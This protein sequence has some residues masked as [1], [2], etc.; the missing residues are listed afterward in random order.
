[1]LLWLVPT[2]TMR[3][4]DVGTF[5]AATTRGSFY[6]KTDVQTSGGTITVDGEFSAPRGQLMNVLSTNKDGLMLCPAGSLKN[7]AP[8]SGVWTGDLTA[9]PQSRNT[10]DFAT[11][12][13]NGGTLSVWLLVGLLLSVAVAVA[14][15]DE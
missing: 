7:C 8:V 1:M 2:V 10:F 6:P 5:V 13:I 9:S 4:S 3:A 14:Y 11:Y 12:N 15:G